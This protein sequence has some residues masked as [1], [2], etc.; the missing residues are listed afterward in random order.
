MARSTGWLRTG[1]ETASRA[2]FELRG[3]K[4]WTPGYNHY[5][6]KTIDSLLGEDTFRREIGTDGFGYRIDERVVEYPWLLDRLP[7]GGADL[8]DAGSTL[9]HAS[10][11][12]HPKIAEKSLFISTLAPEAQAFWDL[13]ISYVYEDLRCSHFRD[14]AFDLIACVST[15]EHVGLDNTMLYTAD[16]AKD[17]RRPGDYLIAIAEMARMLKP[18]GRL[19]VTVPFGKMKNHGWFQVFDAAML[20]QLIERFAPGGVHEEIFRYADD[21]WLRATR[22]E[23]GDATCFDIHE[24]KQYDPDFA[25]F[26]R[27]VACLELVK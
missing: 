16:G 4:P 21:R 6:W 17:E 27:A 3:R 20:D 14:E 8:L 2:V 19:Y 23:A 1:A 12:R 22:E 26:S 5:K 7:A 10:I 9:N 24:Q 15:L 25:A 11:V 13:G 18:G